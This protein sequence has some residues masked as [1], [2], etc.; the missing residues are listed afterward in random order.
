MR[1]R[2][3]ATLPAL[4][5][6]PAVAVAQ[7]HA[8]EH[9]TLTQKVSTTTIALEGDRPVARGRTLFGPDG[10]VK[11]GEVWTPG[12]NWA[13]T[14]EVDRDVTV[15]GHSLPKGKYSLWLTPKAAPS[16]WS[17]SFSRVTHRFHTRPPGAADEQLRIDVKPEQVGMHMETLAWYMP[18]V[19]PDGVTLRLH[20]GTTSVPVQIGVEMPRL[21]TLPSDEIPAYVGTYKTHITPTLGA[22]YDVDLIVQDDAGTLKLSS[23]PRDIFGAPVVMLPVTDGRFHTA[24]PSVGTF[25]GQYFAEKGM[26]FAFKREGDRATSLE[27]YGYDDNL[28]GRGERVK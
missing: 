11:W 28:V 9:F 4:V 19:M 3:L 26:I 25:K 12:A 21:A 2:F 23:Q 22:P 16:P 13:T 14:I 27:M 7:I 1:L 5:I 15:D 8:S 10:V 24:Y 6:A 17:L 18:V 20:W